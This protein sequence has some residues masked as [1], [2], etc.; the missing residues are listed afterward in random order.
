MF[1]LVMPTDMSTPHPLDGGHAHRH[2]YSP[3]TDMYNPHPLDGGHAHRH[4]Y[5]P[6]TGRWSRPQTCL[7]PTHWTVVTP[8]DM[9]TPHPL[10]G[11]HAHRH[12]YSPP[13]GRWSRPQTCLL[14]THWPDQCPRACII[15]TQPVNVQQS[16][17]AE[18]KPSDNLCH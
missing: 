1:E 7:L 13:T 18:A 4:V 8:T 5:S 2:V 11:D 16:K 6:P 10:G 3:P 17:I 15:A 9:S 14:P 12:V